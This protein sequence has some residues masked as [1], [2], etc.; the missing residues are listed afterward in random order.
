MPKNPKTFTV[1]D[2]A[3]FDGNPFE[4]AE[5]A[6]K[7]ARGVAVV[8]RDALEGSR[9]MMRS[10][11]MERQIYATGKADAEAFDSGPQVRI[12]ESLLDNVAGTIKGAE[13][14][15]KAASFN[16]RHPPKDVD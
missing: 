11:E 3:T 16:P 13:L 1:A 2:P 6:L 15:T 7:Q 5:R 12:L 10:A 14:L 9:N 8:L 4:V